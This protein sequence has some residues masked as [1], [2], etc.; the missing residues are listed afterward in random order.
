[1]E[2][3]KILKQQKKKQIQYVEIEKYK[4]SSVSQNV[5][6][7]IGTPIIAIKNKIDMGFVNS[8]SFIIKDINTIQE[9]IIISSGDVIISIPFKDFQKYF[10]VAYCIT[11]HRAQG[12]TYNKP[13]TIH[14]FNMMPRRCKYVS[15]TRAS[16][17]EYVN[18]V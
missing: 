16:K 6:L 8:Q 3:N 10:H 1:M 14:D 9:Q 18:I 17:Y 15:L 5:F 13:Y 12:S 7:T 2:R 11:S 4:F